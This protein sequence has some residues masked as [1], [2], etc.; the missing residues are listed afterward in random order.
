MESA[1]GKNRELIAIHF[2]VDSELTENRVQA[3]DSELTENYAVDSELILSRAFE[4]V[5]K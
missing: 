3:T 5:E 2:Q 1:A 4:G